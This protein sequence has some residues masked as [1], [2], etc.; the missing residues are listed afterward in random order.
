MV[1]S[2]IKDFNGIKVLAMNLPVVI[3]PSNIANSNKFHYI[4]LN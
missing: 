1:V 3:F 4:S 2:K